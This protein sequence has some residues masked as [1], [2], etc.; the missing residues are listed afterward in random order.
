MTILGDC[1][2]SQELVGTN[3]F[4]AKSAAAVRLCYDPQIELAGKQIWLRGD[5]WGSLMPPLRLKGP[6]GF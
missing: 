6:K 3:Q 5:R 1:Y 2:I 4:L